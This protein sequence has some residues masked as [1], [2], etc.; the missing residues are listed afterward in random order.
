MRNYDKRGVRMDLRNVESFIR[1]AELGSFTKA[2]SEMNYVQSTVTMQIQQLEKELGVPLFDRIGKK[3]SLT[4]AGREFLS[5][6]NEI[7]DIMQKAG[8]LGKEDKNISG[9]LR[10]GVLESLL[11]S[12]LVELL[13]GFKEEYPN[14]DIEIKMG[15]SADLLVLLKQNQLDLVYLSAN[16]SGD[17]DLKCYDRREENLVFLAAPDHILAKKEK[18][19]LPELLEYDFLVT[20]RSGICYRRLQE[21]AAR[22]DR[23]VSHSLTV[24]STITIANLVQK[25]MGLAFLPEYSVARLLQ[26]GK[27]VKLNVDLEPQV[28]YRQVFCHKNRWV[29]P[30]MGRLIEMIKEAQ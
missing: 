21:L 9:S 18:L 26:E 20:E 8:T 4:S 1:V 23:T 25:G 3:V 15:Q 13:P 27:L 30:F 19:S 14:V 7:V 10:I 16:L 6:A 2:A 12:T 11:F 5:Y 24:D 22:Y 29:A 17:P 28:Y